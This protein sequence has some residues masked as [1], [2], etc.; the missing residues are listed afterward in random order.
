MSHGEILEIKPLELQFPFE[1]KKQIS[2]SLLLTNNGDDYVAFKVKTTNPKTYCVKPN[3]GLVLPH[4][5]SDV[6]VTMQAQ[7]EAPPDMQCKDK[8]LLQSV[9]V[10]PGTTV[11]DIA[12][13]LFNKDSSH[14]VNECKLRVAYVSPLQPSSPDGSKGGGGGG[15]TSV[16][17]NGHPNQAEFS[18]ISKSLVEQQENA[19][20]MKNAIAKLTD[21]RDSAIKRRNKLQQEV[22][23]LRRHGKRSG[24]GI[25]VIY[26]IVVGLIGMLLGYLLRR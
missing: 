6:I 11:H 15:G 4:S 8:F 19:S 9:V 24:G 14:Q 16:S 3:T 23:A 1:V 7:K 20:E 25:P 2:C 21:E 26:V 18:K 13:E 10:K 12:P 5:T 22:E 17:D